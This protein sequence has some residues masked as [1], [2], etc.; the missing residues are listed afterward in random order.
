[1][2]LA[3]EHHLVEKLTTEEQKN[4][5]NQYIEE[6]SKKT[7]R[8]RMADVKSVSGAFTGSYVTHPF[9]KELIPIYIS[10]YVL[11]GYGTG[12]VMAV[13]AH[14]DR[15]HRFAKYFGLPIKKL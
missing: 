6:T 10:D 5:I 1:M 7:E 4:A 9:T 13:P 2:V 14:D 8:D 3:P 15:D 12:A 11:M